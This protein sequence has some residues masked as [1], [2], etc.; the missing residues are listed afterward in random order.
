MRTTVSEKL[1][2]I[3][4]DIVENGDAPLTRLTV[5][6]KW[7]ATPQ[8]LA[9]F[10][11]W[12]ASRA[13]SRK[14]KTT[15]LAAQLF[16]ESRALLDKVKPYDIHIDRKAAQNLYDRL[17]DFQNDYDQQQWGAVRIIK[18]WNLFLVESGLSIFLWHADV[19]ALGYKLAADYC[20]NYDPQYGYG[21]NGPSV[22]KIQEIARF[23]FTTEARGEVDAQQN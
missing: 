18:N 13:S 6:K 8:R 15:G 5:I 20:Q 16:K 2:Q 7:F 12:V 21:L 9:A 23:M 11:V 1:I 17:L 10:G 3:C 14:G 19:P 4:D 22:T